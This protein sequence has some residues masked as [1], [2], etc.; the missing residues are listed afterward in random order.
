MEW[1]LK[2]FYTVKTVRRLELWCLTPLSTICQLHRGGQFYWWRKP[3]CPEKT[4]DLS[5]ITCSHNVVS[6]TPRLCGIRTRYT[7]RKQLYKPLLEFQWALYF[8]SSFFYEIY[9]N[10][11]ILWWNDN[12]FNL[13]IKSALCWLC[14][15]R[16]W[17]C[18][19]YYVV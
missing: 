4:T 19:Y 1:P 14:G 2:L 3:E 17:S 8:F 15:Q 10:W 13:A 7:F 12:M 16:R 11:N 18:Y 9:I 6:S 5:Q